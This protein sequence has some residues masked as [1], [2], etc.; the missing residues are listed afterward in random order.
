MLLDLLR[1]EV[2]PGDVELLHFRVPVKTDDLHPVLER[3]RDPVEHVRGGDEEDVGQVV[4]H[5]EV[6]VVEGAV[7]LGIEDLQQRRRRVAAEI[8]RHLVHLVEQE[9]GVD[10]ARLLDLLHDL[11]RHRPDVGAAV[12]ADLRLVPHPAQRHPDELPAHRPRDGAGERRLPHARRPDEAQDRALE[13]R[14]ELADG[15]VFEDPLLDLLQ[16]VMV[17]VEDPL[18]LGDVELVLGPLLPRDGDEPVDVVA[19]DGRLGGHGRHHPQ[20]LDLLLR[21]LV[22]LLAHPALLDLLLELVELGAALLAVPKLL[23]DRPHLLVQVELALALLHL[24]LDAAPDPALDLENLDLG[25]HQQQQLLEPLRVGLELEH[26]LLLGNLDGKL[27]REGVGQARRV[28]DPGDLGHE[29]LRDL[30]AELG[31]VLE[32]GVD[33]ADHRLG[34]RSGERRGDR[35]LGAH[36]EVPVVREVVDDLRA[37]P[38]L[39]QHL[40]GAVGELEHLDDVADRA[41]PVDL[42]LFRIVRGRVDLGG[43]EDQ[44][45]EG[46]GRLEGRDGFVPPDEQGDHHAGENDDIPQGKQREDLLAV[47]HGPSLSHTCQASSACFPSIDLGLDAPPPADHVLGDDALADVA[48]GR[49]LVHHVE[50]DVLEDGAQAPRAGLPLDRLLGNGVQRLV[51][52]FELHVLEVEQP[53]VLADQGVFRP[54]EDLHQRVL[55]TARAALPSPEGARRTRG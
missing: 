23:L 44:A 6:M 29:V 27:G 18:G 42:V 48:L 22:R 24:L 36:L 20:L 4:I 25:L 1:D 45:V 54:G 8:R 10:R 9:D 37:Q 55:V 52:E 14:D 50:H 30:L 17:L 21:L 3:P 41:D 35:L 38:A 19:A 47:C 31:E 33:V 13:L 2:P 32:G 49:D 40:D 51:G 26:R 39:D 53:L 7:L 43:E 15:E 11:P 28:V 34:R 16:A 5:V 46:E 12:A